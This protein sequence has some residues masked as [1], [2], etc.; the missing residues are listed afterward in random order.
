MSSLDSLLDEVCPTCRPLFDVVLR[1]N[2]EL[3][4][5][6]SLLERRLAAYENAH[7]PPSQRRFQKRKDTSREGKK[8]GRPPG[9]E[10]VT[11]P[12]PEPDRVVE[13][14]AE[15]CPRCGGV[16]GDPVHVENRV[17]EEIPEPRPV[18]VTDF[19]IH[20]YQCPQCGLPV[21]ASHPECPGRGR[22]GPRTQAHI[23]FL[24]YECR[25][26]H[27]RIARV[28]SQQFGL[29]VS[30]ATVWNITRRVAGKLTSEY[31]RILQRIR[32]SNVVYADETGFH[33]D[34]KKWWLWTFTTDSDT[35][36]VLRPS[37]GQTVVKEILGEDYNGIVVCDGWK[38]YPTLENATLQRCWS[39][40]LR[41]A[42]EVADKEAEAKPLAKAL[43]RLYK[44]TTEVVGKDPPSS[45][46][47]HIYYKARNRL[48]RWTSKNYVAE[49]VQKLV[50]K[51]RNGFNHWFTF[52]VYPGVEATNNKAER[53]L[54]EHVVIRKIIS[55]L[56]NTH[57]THTHEVNT[58]LLA[59]WKQQNLNPYT[60]LT[61]QLT[62]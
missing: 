3:K 25:L 12:L 1:E 27:R 44:Q 37:R 59:T 22:F 19:H 47:Q 42:D 21:E 34:G 33:V 9:C 61:T 31:H 11:R 55:T 28:L 10:G 54:R 6:I 45:E 24:K 58:T 40:L 14:S 41:E 53:S 48:R 39:H 43:H 5:Q 50:E 38:A 62:S 7:T 30:A 17:V 4:R 16:L 60:Q 13:V 26:P 8:R 51:I 20:S 52:I 32:R 18:T 49:S 29:D 46:R 15:E 36:V 2:A 23:T 56:R 57:G 35:L